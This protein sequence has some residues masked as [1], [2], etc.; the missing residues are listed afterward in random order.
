MSPAQET[1]L[2]KLSMTPRP[3]CPTAGA[4]VSYKEHEFLRR[5]LVASPS[6]TEGLGCY[7]SRPAPPGEPVYHPEDKRTYRPSL[8][9]AVRGYR[10]DGGT[11]PIGYAGSIQLVRGKPHAQGCRGCEQGACRSP[12]VVPAHSAGQ[13]QFSQKRPE[14]PRRSAAEM[15][16]RRPAQLSNLCPDYRE[17]G[18]EGLKLQ[19]RPARWST[20]ASQLACLRK[21]LLL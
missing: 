3:L 18:C 20:P 17:A 15:G 10:R 19:R 6:G 9:G 13:F 2:T 14:M 8:P 16:S 1:P 12:P 7:K 21:L 5:N 11:P 4:Q